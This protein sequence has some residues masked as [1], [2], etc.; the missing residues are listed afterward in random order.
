[1]HNTVNAYDDSTPLDVFKHN[2]FYQVGD[3]VFN[4]KFNALEYATK[5][6]QDITWNFN[7]DAFKAVDWKTPLN[8]DLR[9]LYKHRAQQLRDKYDYLS[10]SFSGGS[11]STTI[12]QSFI[13]NNIHLDEIIC[14]WPVSHTS[15]YSLSLDP[16]P[17]N[18]IHEWELAIKPVLEYVKTHHPKIKITH[19]DS[20]DKLIVDDDEH[21]FS[22]SHMCPYPSTRRYR[23]IAK[24]V[25]E[26]KQTIDNSAI[27][28]GCEKPHI[29]IEKNVLCTLFLDQHT[30]F[31]SSWDPSPRTVEYF[32]WAADFPEIVREQCH[33][34]LQHVIQNPQC[35]ALFDY[36]KSYSSKQEQRIHLRN[37]HNLVRTII[38]PDWD[39]SVF[40]ADK[41]DSMIYSR[42]YAWITDKRPPVIDAW[43]S[44]L[45]SRVNVIDPK[46][47]I[48]FDNSKQI[49]T[50]KHFSSRLYP[51]GILP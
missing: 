46:Y 42:Q 9:T 31:K 5:T 11:D 12:L 34:I 22:I 36:T 45:K 30:F 50:V 3:K 33:A 47:F 13:N 39:L 43:E 10:L 21:T 51:I 7:D 17:F 44:A 19:I 14:E 18:Y 40:Q 23:E 29:R 28:L 49:H 8:V 26:I 41:A 48:F 32:Y 35:R 6:R 38:Y 16:D 15:N 1:M 4:F 20:L 24:R 27:I 37:M 2:G 25:G